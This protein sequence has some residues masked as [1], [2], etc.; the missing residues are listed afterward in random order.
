MSKQTLVAEMLR[1]KTRQKGEKSRKEPYWKRR[2][3]N[4]VKTWRRHLSKL[5]EVRK[6]NHALC[7]KDKKRHLDM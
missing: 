1:V 7:E 2:I 4:N 3:E 5:E 6:V